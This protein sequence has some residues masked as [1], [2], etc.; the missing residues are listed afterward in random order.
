LLFTIGRTRSNFNLKF[1]F[2]SKRRRAARSRVARGLGKR[3]IS[4]S[5]PINGIW[6]GI[7]SVLLKSF[8]HLVDFDVGRWLSDLANRAFPFRPD[9]RDV[10]RPFSP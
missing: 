10:E 6:N 5:P 9:E 3:R 4:L 2:K 8:K 1:V 7:L